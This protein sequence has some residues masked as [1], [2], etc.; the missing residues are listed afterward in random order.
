MTSPDSDRQT[1]QPVVLLVENNRFLS[2]MMCEWMRSSGYQV[3][4]AGN[5]REALRT[6]GG[7]RFDLVLLD[8]D[9][10]RGEGLSLLASVESKL[11]G[12]SLVLLTG[13]VNYDDVL[14]RIPAHAPCVKVEKPYSFFALGLVMKSVLARS[15]P[16]NDKSGP[17]HAACW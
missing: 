15:R 16:G 3:Q 11:S 9:L 12:A 14:A 17:R 10:N 1:S 5:E 13:A 4:S 2:E 6:L 8:L 7:Q